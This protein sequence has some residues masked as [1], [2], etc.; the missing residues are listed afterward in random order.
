MKQGSKDIAGQGGRR[1]LDWRA[2]DCEGSIIL[3]EHQ[4][5]ARICG[6]KGC[7]ANLFLQAPPVL[8]HL[9]HLAAEIP[10]HLVG[11]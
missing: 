1:V 9:A 4:E 2:D 7:L 6:C 8:L 10:Q 5:G 11:I 3:V